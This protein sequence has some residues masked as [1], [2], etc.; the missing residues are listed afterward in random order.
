MMIALLFITLVI[1]V[2]AVPGHVA[3]LM[4][5][6]TEWPGGLPGWAYAGLPVGLLL[7]VVAVRLPLRAGLRSLERTEF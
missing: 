6:K 1:S 2:A 3:G 4:K 7:T 5:A